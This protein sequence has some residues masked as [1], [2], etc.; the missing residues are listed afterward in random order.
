MT[1][2]PKFNSFEELQEWLASQTESDVE[3]SKDSSESAVPKKASKS[4]PKKKPSS[5]KKPAKSDEGFFLA[6]GTGQTTQGFDP[7]I[8]SS[9]HFYTRPGDTVAVTRNDA[10]EEAKFRNDNVLVFYHGHTFG[11]ACDT[12][13]AQV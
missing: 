10:K 9:V 6:K 12:S 7:N 1:D 2:T 11:E 5:K 4:S 8:W 13:C 3:K